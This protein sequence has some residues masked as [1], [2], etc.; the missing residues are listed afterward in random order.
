MTLTLTPVTQQPA[1][2]IAIAFHG[3][4]DNAVRSLLKA[5]KGKKLT[6]QQAILEQNAGMT[7]ALDAIR[8]YPKEVIKERL[9]QEASMGHHDFVKGANEVLAKDAAKN[10]YKAK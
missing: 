4:K 1:G 3:S 5:M 9:M 8:K 6:P 10:I 7:Y 2:A